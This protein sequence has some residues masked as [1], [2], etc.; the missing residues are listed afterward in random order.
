MDPEHMDDAHSS[1]RWHNT[2]RVYLLDHT[3]SSGTF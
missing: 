1:I 2:H 3:C